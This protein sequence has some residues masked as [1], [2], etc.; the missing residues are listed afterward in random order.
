[1]DTTD[2]V[3]LSRCNATNGDKW[4]YDE[5]VRIMLWC[6]LWEK[7]VYKK[8]LIH[9]ILLGLSSNSVLHR[10]SCTQPKPNLV[11]SFETFSIGLMNMTKSDCTSPNS[12]TVNESVPN[13]SQISLVGFDLLQL[14]FECLYWFRYLNLEKSNSPF[15]NGLVLSDWSVDGCG[16]TMQFVRWTTKMGDYQIRR[17]QAKTIEWCEQQLIMKIPHNA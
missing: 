16:K 1:M 15:G 5:S 13:E 3:V 4:E 7:F 12:I 14:Y 8:R 9:S 10:K 2:H 11:D 17:L 6:I